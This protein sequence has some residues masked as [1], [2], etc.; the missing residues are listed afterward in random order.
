MI[1]EPAMKMPGMLGGEVPVKLIA[2]PAN[3]NTL[4]LD[5]PLIKVMD[6]MEANVMAEPAVMKNWALWSPRPFK[7]ILVPAV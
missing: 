7:I 5:A 2:V 6:E 1:A 3:Q 4:Q